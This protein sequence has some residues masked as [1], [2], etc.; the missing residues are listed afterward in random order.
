MDSG[1]GL[2]L[3]KVGGSGDPQPE[4]CLKIT[5]GASKA[6]QAQALLQNVLIYLFQGSGPGV[7]SF[8]CSL[9]DSVVRSLLRTT[10]PT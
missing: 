3:P 10:W 8:K 6:I 1:R 4:L 7:S 5:L 2:S 9:E